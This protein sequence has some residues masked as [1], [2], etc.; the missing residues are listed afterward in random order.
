MERVPPSLRLAEG[1]IYRHQLKNPASGLVKA[2]NYF[3]HELDGFSGT[4]LYDFV[5]QLL[6]N[7]NANLNAADVATLFLFEVIREWAIL[8]DAKLF[9][10]S[11]GVAKPQ[12]IRKAVNTRI[13]P[14]MLGTALSGKRK[15]PHCPT[16]PDWEDN[17]RDAESDDVNSKKRKLCDWADDTASLGD[18]GRRRKGQKV[19]ED[20]SENEKAESGKG[21]R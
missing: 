1:D 13:I 5:D 16:A 21:P 14:L 2:Y 19:D 9:S 7:T 20:T 8:D 10:L 18:R 15:Q 12:N 11:G 3:R 4:H 17:G 6:R